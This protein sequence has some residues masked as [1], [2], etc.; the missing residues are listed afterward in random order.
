MNISDALSNAIPVAFRP[1][2]QEVGRLASHHKQ[3]AV[4]VGGVVRDLLMGRP[5]RDVD[6]MVD[7]PAG[8]IVAGLKERFNADVTTHERFMT[9]SLRLPSGEKI[10][11]TTARE[12]RYAAPAQ[13]PNVTPS[14]ISAD[15]KRRDFSVN[16]IACSLL[17]SSLGEVMD[18]FQGGRDISAK[19]IKTLHSRSF[20]DDPT[21]LFRA[22]RFAGRFSFTLEPATQQQAIDAIRGKFPE[23]LSATRLRHEFELILKESNPAPALALLGQWGLLPFLC[24][25]WVFSD[26]HRRSLLCVEAPVVDRA[27]FVSRLAAWFSPWGQAKAREMMTSLGFERE[28]KQE[29]L[30][31]L[32]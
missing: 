14:V 12:E 9:F 7:H 10:D 5:I 15:L 2:L 11:V 30:A 16:A 31:R 25:D 28:T 19:Q 17:P 3:E 21:R 32:S 24:P 4:L 8:P 13:L 6:V 27:L 29:V 23:R 22:A 26:A 18:P 20:Q 1:F